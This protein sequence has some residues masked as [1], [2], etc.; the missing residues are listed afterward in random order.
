MMNNNYFIQ[1]SIGFI[2]VLHCAKQEKNIQFY[3]EKTKYYQGKIKGKK[4]RD[5]VTGQ[6]GVNQA[7]C[8]D[9]DKMNINQI[10]SKTIEFDNSDLTPNVPNQNI[11]EMNEY[12]EADRLKAAQENLAF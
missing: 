5:K 12:T 7:Y 11:E 8:F 6:E 1:F 10:K 4:F 2:K 9:Y 3:I